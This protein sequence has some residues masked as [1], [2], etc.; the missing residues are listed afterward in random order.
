[1]RP[2]LLLLL[3][4]AVTRV[5]AAIDLDWHDAQRSRDVPVRVHLPE[6]RAP[7]PVILFS[8]GLGGS[9]EGYAF[10]GEHWARAGF[11][12][13]H[14]QHRGSD[15]QVWRGVRDRE[16]SLRA[17]ASLQNAID[18]AHDVTFAIDQ[19][20]ALTR[21]QT[22]PLAGRADLARI[23]M[24]GHSFGA[25]TTLLVAGMGTEA[26]SFADPRIQAALV[27]SPPVNRRDPRP[28][29]AIRVPFL[30]LTGTADTSIIADTK[31]SDRRY[32]FDSATRADRALVIFQDADHMVFAGRGSCPNRDAIMAAIQ[33][34]TTDFWRAALSRDPEAATRLSA[35]ALKH[36]LGPLATTVETRP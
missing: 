23:G 33:G 32:P 30:L 26:A 36:R 24:G 15:N 4:L 35:A 10:L 27:M 22:G 5:P 9:R 21:T 12:V 6:S 17:A 13:V 2:R 29:E 3:L 14:L 16:K 7:A 8:H 1:M 34:V 31:P 19:L 18:R 28:Y 20:T 25:N 11:L